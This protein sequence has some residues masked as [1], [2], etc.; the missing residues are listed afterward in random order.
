MATT[1]FVSVLLSSAAILC[2]YAEACTLCSA[3]C[4]NM[5]SPTDDACPHGCVLNPVSEPPSCAA[6]SSSPAPEVN[7]TSADA[8]QCITMKGCVLWQGRCSTSGAAMVNCS[9]L[10]TSDCILGPAQTQCWVDSSVQRCRPGSEVNC[11]LADE[12]QCITMTG[13][14]LWQ[15]QCS[16]ADAVT[17]N[18]SS[19]NTSDCI[20]GPAQSQCWVDTCSQRCR[21]NS[22][23]D[24]TA[25]SSSITTT[26][27]SGA[28]LSFA[29]SYASKAV[30]LSTALPSILVKMSGGI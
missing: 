1:H 27:K 3:E 20:L 28:E 23:D 10:S 26:P 19:L 16:S 22:E 13:C 21:P 25:C 15:G 24:G 14:V 9:S 5:C 6:N 12:A 29:F 30:W 11:A 2:R 4:C 7:C 18:C 8:A 17:V